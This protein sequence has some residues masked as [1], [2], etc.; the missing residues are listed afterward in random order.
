MLVVPLAASALSPLGLGAV[1]AL[2][3]AL[4]FAALAVTLLLER[5]EAAPEAS[6][7]L[8]SAP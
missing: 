1:F 7:A 3:A 5:A 6:R 2:G 8:S 4:F